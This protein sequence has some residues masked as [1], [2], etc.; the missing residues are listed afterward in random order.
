VISAA[1]QGKIGHFKGVPEANLCIW[2]PRVFPPKVE[3]VAQGFPNQDNFVQ[4]LSSLTRYHGYHGFCFTSTPPS[5]ARCSALST[6]ASST[7]SSDSKNRG[8][9]LEKDASGN[10]KWSRGREKVWKE[11]MRTIDKARFFIACTRG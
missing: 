4:Y 3:I 11:G 8:Y 2:E 1:L 5:T 7:L 10:E 9:L 6:H